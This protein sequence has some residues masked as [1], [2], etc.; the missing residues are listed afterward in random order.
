[1]KRKMMKLLSILLM[2]TLLLCACG[3]DSSPAGIVK[4]QLTDGAWETDMSEGTTAVYTFTKKGEF[5]CDATVTLGEQSASLTRGGTYEI[6]EADGEVTV[7]LHYPNVNYEV[8]IT[9]QKNGE[10]YSFVI[11]GCPMNRI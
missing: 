2:A 6:R 8:E 10:Q 1:M 11:A 5:T 3:T 4:K 7:V 9:C